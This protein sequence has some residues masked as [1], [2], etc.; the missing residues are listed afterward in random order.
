MQSSKFAQYNRDQTQEEFEALKLSIKTLGQLDP[1]VS[2]KGEILDGRHRYKAC[3]ELGIQPVI[4]QFEGSDSDAEAFVQAKEV[5]RHQ[6]LS[7]LAIQAAMRWQEKKSDNLNI[8]DFFAAYGVQS[9]TR[10]RDSIR[11]LEKNRDTAERV[12]RGEMP[13][14]RA[15]DLHFPKVESK[16]VYKRIKPN[17]PSDDDVTADVTSPTREERA[18]LKTA[19][20]ELEQAKEQVKALQAELDTFAALENSLK[21]PPVRFHKAPSGHRTGTAVVLASDWHV[22][23]PV[24][25]DKV[26]GLNEYDLEICKRRVGRMQSGILNLLEMQRQVFDIKTLVL[27]LGG[28]FIQG[29]LRNDDRTNNLLPPLEATQFAQDRIVEL[30]DYILHNAQYIE[31]IIIPTSSGNH[32]RTEEKPSVSDHEN[33]NYENHMYHSIQRFYRENPRVQMQIASGLV[34]YLDV[35]G[36]RVR[37]IHGHVIKSMGGVGGI[38]IPINKWIAR[39]DRGIQANLTCMGHFHQQLFMNHLFTNGSMIG[40]DDYAQSIGASPERPKQVEFIIDAKEGPCSYHDLWLEP[41]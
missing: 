27:W 12:F 19:R 18:E 28:D 31:R 1:I 34:N 24:H 35:Y 41:R 25:T 2:Y 32:G 11:L 20:K 36:F 9:P 23:K 40:Y 33:L 22:E 8:H 14:Y 3:I 17:F 26:N 4:V 21:V 10:V 13:M 5:R 6:T 37:F 30:I 29:Y 15:M 39:M 7:Q 38:T 16:I